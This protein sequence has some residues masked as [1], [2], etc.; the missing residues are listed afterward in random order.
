MFLELFVLF[1]YAYLVIGLI[2]YSRPSA[3]ALAHA[4][5][6]D[7]KAMARILLIVCWLPWVVKEIRDTLKDAERYKGF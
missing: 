4:Y 3:R 5:F 6:P 1:A 7:S 2:L